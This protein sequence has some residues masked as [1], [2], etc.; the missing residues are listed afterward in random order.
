MSGDVGVTLALYDATT[1]GTALWSEPQTVHVTNGLLS[2]AL[3]AVVP[4]PTSLDFSQAYFVGVSVG[5]D[6][7][8]QPRLALQWAPYA[9]FAQNV[10]NDPTLLNKVS[11][12]A[13]SSD[14]ANIGI[15]TT[16]PEAT[17]EISKPVAGGLGPVLRLTG[18]SSIGA[19]SALELA[20]YQPSPGASPSTRIVA[21][22]D[23]NY[24][25]ALDFMT[26]VSGAMGNPLVS[27]LRITDDGKV[28]VG[29]TDP[30]V[31][32]DVAGTVSVRGGVIQKGGAPI[33]STSDLGL[34][35]SGTN[36]MRFVTGG[37]PF[38]FFTNTTQ[39]LAGLPAADSTAMTIAAN[40]RVGIG[41]TNPQA[42]LDV[43][44]TIL[45][46]NGL[47]VG[48]SA[49]LR[50]VSGRVRWDGARAGGDS[51]SITVLAPGSYLLTFDPAFTAIP[52]VTITAGANADG[53]PFVA[54]LADDKAADHVVV[55]TWDIQADFGAGKNGNLSPQ[56]FQFIAV[57][58]R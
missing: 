22:D 7:E 42:M 1:G 39:G 40:G 16:A 13:M 47:A 20:P 58:T 12:G 28:G 19:Q 57:G 15:G 18:G 48:A 29:A 27:R 56:S 24:S 46:T 3:G 37:G 55:N 14:G 30:G 53:R 10:A 5:G 32:L 17:V 9:M 34:Y 54:T 50:I 45:T 51:Y 36:W 38:Q 35:S 2:A 6:A 26:K 8:M 21:T 44:G 25:G 49:N 33:T 41:T 52:V 31:T 43:H 4:F 11:G 23:G